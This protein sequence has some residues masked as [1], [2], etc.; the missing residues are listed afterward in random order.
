MG[1]PTCGLRLTRRSTWNGSFLAKFPV[2]DSVRMR[3]EA[4][5]VSRNHP[6]EPLGVGHSEGTPVET[7]LPTGTTLVPAK[8]VVEAGSPTLSERTSV[9]RVGSSPVDTVGLTTLPVN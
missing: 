5:A 7:P 6:V 2:T 4:C 9:S 1:V 3:Q 8:R